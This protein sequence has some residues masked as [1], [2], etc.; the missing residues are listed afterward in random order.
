ML[1]QE[2]L[3]LSAQFY[4]TK[5][6]IK[7]LIRRPQSLGQYPHN[8]KGEIRGLAYKKKKLLFRDGNKLNVGDR[9]GRR[10]PWLAVNQSHFTKN[11]VNRKIGHR[12]VADLNANITALDNEKIVSLLAFAENNTAGSYSARLNIITS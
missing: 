2:R 6:S 3:A 8:R 10:A 4:R 1:R 7:G 5:I 11:I 9:H 12:S